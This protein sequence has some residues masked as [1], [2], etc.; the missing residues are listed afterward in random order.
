M[1]SD[2][3]NVKGESLWCSL[4]RWL[5]FPDLD[6]CFFALR[7]KLFKTG[8]FSA[9]WTGGLTALEKEKRALGS[10]NTQLFLYASQVRLKWVKW[11]GDQLLCVRPGLE[12]AYWNCSKPI[13]FPG[14]ELVTWTHCPVISPWC[15]GALR[16]EVFVLPAAVVSHAGTLVYAIARAGSCPCL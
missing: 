5:L 7:K 16:A 14:N 9:C 1:R 13:R 11:E 8:S 4:L 12:P 15:A 2:L 10:R 3:P 6:L